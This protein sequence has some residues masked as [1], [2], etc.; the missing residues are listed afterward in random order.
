MMKVKRLPDG[1]RSNDA[2]SRHPMFGCMKGLI[3]V[4]D[5]CD[6]TAPMF[7]DWEVDE[8]ADR[9]A[10]RIAE[11]APDLVVPKLTRGGLK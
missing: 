11:R 6:L 4:A 10:D 2:A 8:M 9:L 3:E 5:G 1:T 7:E